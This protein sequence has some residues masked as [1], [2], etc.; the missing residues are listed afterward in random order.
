MGCRIYTL[1]IGGRPMLCFPASNHQEAQSLL[2]EE[3]LR[4]GLREMRSGGMPL[5]DGREK[6]LSKRG[7]G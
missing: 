7:Q 6:L 2:K 4:A 3:W 1:V 5:W